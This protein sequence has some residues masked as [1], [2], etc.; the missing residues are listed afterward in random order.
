[1]SRKRAVVP[2]LVLVGCAFG[3]SAA[4]PVG[5][6]PLA[7]VTPSEAGYADEIAAWRAEREA[8]LRADDGWLT[9]AGLFW[10]KEGPNRVG[11]A[12]DNDVVLPA[13]APAHA[14]SIELRDGVARYALEMGVSGATVAGQPA[15]AAG[16]LRADSAG[17][18]TLLSFGAVSLHVIQRGERFG[19]RVRDKDAAARRDF[20]GRAW[21]ALDPRWRIVARFEPHARPTHVRVPN[22]LGQ[23]SEMPS[24]GTAVFTLDGREV[25]L[26]PVLESDDAEELFFIFKDGSSGRETYPAGR[27]LYTSLPKGGLVTLDFNRAVNP[28]CA[29]TPYAT[30][31]LPPE[32]NRLTS[33]IPAGERLSGPHP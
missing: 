13:P 20:K 12:S 11:S 17:E 32:S 19:V 27:F 1:M 15:P 31:P 25:R 23:V 26:T 3:V 33:A 10:L 2:R 14:L 16:E 22:V 18:P 5:A 24:P 28:P 8:K 6:P 7:H 29:F 30:C 9:V 4:E 21:Y